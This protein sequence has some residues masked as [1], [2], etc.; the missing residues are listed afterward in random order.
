MGGRARGAGRDG[1][2]QLLGGVCECAGVDRVVGDQPSAR[3]GDRVL[4]GG[5]R[6]AGVKDRKDR[7]AGLKRSSDPLDQRP[8]NTS[9]VLGE[10]AL[11]DRSTAAGVEPEVE[12]RRERAAGAPTAPQPQRSAT[13]TVNPRPGQPATEPRHND[14]VRHGRR[15]HKNPLSANT[16]DPGANREIRLAK[17]DD[18]LPRPMPRSPSLACH[19]GGRGFESRRSRPWQPRSG[20]VLLCGPR[21]HEAPLALIE[22]FTAAIRRRT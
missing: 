4:E 17:S 1:R 10:R 15:V 2:A 19:A 12:H 3:A 5:R 8:W 14:R 22:R 18:A 21:R 9:A 20:G 7:G 11:G 13:F 6:A 16:P